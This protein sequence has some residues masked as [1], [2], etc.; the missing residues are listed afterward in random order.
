MHSES[1]SVESRSLETL[2]AAKTERRRLIAVGTTSCRVLET[3]ADQILAESGVSHRENLN[4]WTDIFIYPGFDFRITEAMLTNFH[5]PRST[6][7]MLVA[8]FAGRDNILAAYKEAV[9]L[10]Y[11]FYSYGDAMLII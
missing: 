8:A 5:L 7:L 4:G 1:Y 11:R 3:I 9:K 2:R 10:K 6:L